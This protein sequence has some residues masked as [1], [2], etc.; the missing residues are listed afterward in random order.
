MRLSPAFLHGGLDTLDKGTGGATC[1]N[2]GRRVWRMDTHK[3]AEEV[4]PGA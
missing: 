4:V 2:G 3:R 1:R